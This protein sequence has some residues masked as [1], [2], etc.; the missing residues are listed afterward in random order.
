[1]VVLKYLPTVCVTLGLLGTF[2]GLSMTMSA[3]AAL[4]TSVN[5]ENASDSMTSFLVELPEA[6]KG[7]GVAFHTSLYGIGSSLIAGLYLMMSLKASRCF[8]RQIS[9]KLKETGLLVHE[10][11]EVI[12]SKLLTA[13]LQI[14]ESIQKHD[15]NTNAAIVS[16]NKLREGIQSLTEIMS[17]DVA[18][19]EMAAVVEDGSTVN[20]L[21]ISLDGELLSIDT[22]STPD[23]TIVDDDWTLDLA[24][25]LPPSALDD[26]MRPNDGTY[27]ISLEVTDA[28]QNVAREDITIE[29]KSSIET[30]ELNTLIQDEGSMDGS[31][32]EYAGQVLLTFDS[33][34]ILVGTADAYARI[35]ITST[36]GISQTSADENGNWEVELSSLEHQADQDVTLT[37]IAQDDFGNANISNVTVHYDDGIA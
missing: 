22:S 30:P 26:D 24:S 7:M 34:P 4:V 19:T 16:T 14:E 5:I 28:Y 1:M 17:R 6:I 36:F 10:S 29:I 21:S 12:S 32:T 13:S 23:G 2:I 37:I 27:T 15:K 11:N 3:L 9:N 8:E 18:E 35:F 20:I 31:S 33:T 25:F